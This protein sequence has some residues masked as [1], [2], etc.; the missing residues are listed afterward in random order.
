VGTGAWS[1]FERYRDER[2]NTAIEK[3]RKKNLFSALNGNADR[4]EVLASL[5][6]IFGPEEVEHLTAVYSTMAAETDREGA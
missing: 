4:F 5:K 6:L 1:I 3:T 2:I